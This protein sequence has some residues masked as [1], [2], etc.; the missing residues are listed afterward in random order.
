[1]VANLLDAVARRPD[2]LSLTEGLP[3]FVRNH[4]P[5][6]YLRTGKFLLM[7]QNAWPWRWTGVSPSLRRQTMLRVASEASMRRARGVVRI[8]GAIP[9][10]GTTA[11]GVLHNVLDDGFEKLLDAP[12][13]DDV[14]LPERYVLCPGSVE[15]Y[16]NVARLCEAYRAY[17]NAGGTTSLVVVGGGSA[18][19]EATVRAFARAHEDMTYVGPRDRATTVHLMHRSWATVFPSLVEASPL[20][21]LEAFAVA[22]RVALSRVTGH[23]ELVTTHGADVHEFDAEDVA[24]L[25]T[26]LHALDTA[27][28]A[29]PPAALATPEARTALRAAWADDL[30]ERVSALARGQ[31]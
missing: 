28:V 20:G 5:L 1:M 4:A 13:P 15:P 11:P 21:L 17:R 25:A 3:L 27:P 14:V 2:V 7:P 12:P 19:S 18:S 6:P 29:K 16:R 26:T 22:P 8:S 31:D 30:A 24:G 9:P 23:R 10:I